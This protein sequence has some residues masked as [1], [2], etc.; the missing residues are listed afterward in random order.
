MK[1]FP[2]EGSNNT[3]KKCVPL[4]NMAERAHFY[5]LSDL[6]RRYMHLARNLKQMFVSTILRSSYSPFQNTFKGNTLLLVGGENETD[7][8]KST[9]IHFKTV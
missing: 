7:S 8:V 4:F 6:L 5:I 3:V 1:D 9:H 2:I